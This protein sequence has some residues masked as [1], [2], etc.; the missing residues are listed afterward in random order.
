[1]GKKLKKFRVQI[2]EEVRV[3]AIVE[4]RSE[5][6]AMEKAD[7]GDYER[8]HNANQEV[9]GFEATSAEEV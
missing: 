7:S 4:A 2:L 8:E 6:E 9:Q 3:S 1:M 5:E